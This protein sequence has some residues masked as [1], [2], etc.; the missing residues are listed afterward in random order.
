MSTV[1][2]TTQPR[3]ERDLVMTSTCAPS[4]DIRVTVE[5]FD[6]LFYDPSDGTFKA[7]GGI[8]NPYVPM[9]ENPPASGDYGLTLGTAGWLD[10]NYKTDLFDHTV[11]PGNPV[12]LQDNSTIFIDSSSSAPVGTNKTKVDHNYQAVDALQYVTSSNDPVE[13]ADVYAF[14]QAQ[15]D[16]NAPT[17][18]AIAVTKTDSKGRWIAPFFLD[19]GTYVILFQKINKYGPDTRTINVI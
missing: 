6:G 15:Y 14:T 3:V 2:Q 10:G 11:D 4:R 9:T 19:T 5:R 8:T 13:G 1:T 12:Q 18:Q 7:L 16:A 17:L